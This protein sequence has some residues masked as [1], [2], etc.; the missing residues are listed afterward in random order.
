MWDPKTINSATRT[1][2]TISA[3]CSFNQ[4]SCCG[5]CPPWLSLQQNQPTLRI[6]L[7][8]WRGV[9]AKTTWYCITFSAFE[10]KHCPLLPVLCMHS[11]KS[12][13]HLHELAKLALVISCLLCALSKVEAGWSPRPHRRVFC[14]TLYPSQWAIKEK[15]YFHASSLSSMSAEADSIQLNW[16]LHS[17]SN[18]LHS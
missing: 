9:C 14:L 2:K 18:A 13:S 17:K 12:F 8:E 4:N 7:T 3:T 5:H 1:P 6:A 10:K 11:S 15:F 16:L